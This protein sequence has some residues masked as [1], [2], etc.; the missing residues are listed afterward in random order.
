MKGLHPNTHLIGQDDGRQRLSTPALIVEKPMLEQNLRTAARL[1]AS[2]GKQLRPHFKA[3]KSLEIAKLQMDLGAVGIS[4]ATVTEAEAVSTLG[5]DILLTSVVSTVAHQARVAD[6]AA[7]GTAITLVVDSPDV[8]ALLE[9]ELHSRNTTLDILIDIDM[10]RG[11]SGC[12]RVEDAQA[13]AQQVAHSDQCRFRGLQTYAGQLSHMRSSADRKSAHQNTVARTNAFKTSL[14]N[15]WPEDAII[16]GGS[17]GSMHLDLNGPLTELQCGSYALMDVEYL[18]IEPGWDAWP[19]EPAVF[20]QSAVLSA[21]WSDHVVT[22]AGDKWFRSKY[23]TTPI[24]V[25]STG[26]RQPLHLLSDE[27]AR[28]DT[29]HMGRPSVGDRIECIPPH[30]DPTIGLYSGIHACNGDALI[31]IWPTCARGQ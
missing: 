10:G 18:D 25:S 15:V 23:D 8:L 22:D 27:H 9:R 2:A 12:V 30:C 26:A 29:D 31:E 24:V 17:T 11:R 13:L 1:A 21:N 14:S 19:F 6:L 28:L 7:A 5:V 20:V 4:V 3:H 16:S